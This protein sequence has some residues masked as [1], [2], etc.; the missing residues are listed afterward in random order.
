MTILIKFF[1]VLRS[2]QGEFDYFCRTLHF[3][4]PVDIEN[5]I[6]A[7]VTYVLSRVWYILDLVVHTYHPLGPLY[8]LGLEKGQQ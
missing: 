7:S 8:P 1:K 5:S 3:V 2:I 6:R 4:C